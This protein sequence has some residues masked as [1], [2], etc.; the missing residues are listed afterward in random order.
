[1]PAHG[2]WLLAP[3][4]VEPDLTLAMVCERLAAAHGAKADASMLSRFFAKCGIG[5]KKKPSRVRAVAA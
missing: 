3:I 4:E 1:M 5:F 2:P